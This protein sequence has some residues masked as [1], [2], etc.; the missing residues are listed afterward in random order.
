MIP[1]NSLPRKVRKMQKSSKMSNQP[2]TKSQ[3]KQMIHSIVNYE[4]EQKYSDLVANSS[5]NI[6]W[7]GI[8]PFALTDI[9]QGSSDLTRV[10]D[11][12]I[13]KKVTWSLLLKYNQTSTITNLANSCNV[14]RVLIFAW[15][16]FFTD[17]APTAAKVLTYTGTYYACHGPLTHD[18]ID[19]IKVISDTVHVLDGISQANK[20]IRGSVKLNHAVHYKNASQ[21]NASNGIYVLLISDAQASVGPYPAVADYVFRVDFHDD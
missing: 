20:L 3:V 19:Q 12:L 9:A 6:D 18:G 16:P 15:K 17:V 13:V 10:G 8:A 2:V 4:S 1:A 5:Q 14:V 7:N 21:S 11:E